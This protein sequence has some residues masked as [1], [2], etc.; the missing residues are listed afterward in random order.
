[1]PGVYEAALGQAFG[2]LDPH[3]QAIF[4][5]AASWVGSG[6]FDEVG[7][8]HFWLR[9]ALAVMVADRALPGGHGTGVPFDVTSRSHVEGDGRILQ[10]TERHFVIAGHDYSSVS[11]TVAELDAST[12]GW[13]VTDY[14]GDAPRLV[15][16]VAV[17]ESGGALRLESTDSRFQALGRSV[18]MWGPLG[19]QA[20][21]LHRWDAGRQQ[22]HI[23]VDVRHPLLGTVL[24][25]TGYF[26][27]ELPDL[28][29]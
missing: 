14:L 13:T 20:V 5:P 25:Y 4:G 23:D 11:T 2:R 1:M 10:R 24:S 15:T 27:V 18:P 12:G 3:L 19:A 17:S 9:P 8:R 21:T 28:A 22:H 7:A 29:A 16:A 26:D 6:I